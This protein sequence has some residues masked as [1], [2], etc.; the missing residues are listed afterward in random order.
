MKILFDPIAQRLSLNIPQPRADHRK[1]GCTLSKIPRQ[2]W[3]W[4]NANNS[5][6]KLGAHCLSPDTLT[7]D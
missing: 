7:L 3:S 5:G 4:S 1:T 6:R 2:R